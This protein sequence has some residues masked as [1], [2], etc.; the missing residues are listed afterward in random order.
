MTI[1]AAGVL[2]IVGGRALFLKRSMAGDHAGEWCLPAGKIEGD[3]TPEA[4]ARREFF[5]ETG[6]KLKGDLVLW[7]HR[8]GPVPVINAPTPEGALPPPMPPVVDFTCFLSVDESE[9]E[10]KVDDEHDGYAWAVPTSPPEPLHPGCRINLDRINMDELGMARAIMA[11]DL[12]SPQRFHNM[13]LFDL[14]ITG[15]ETAYRDTIDEIVYRLPDKY[16]SPDF[17]ARC[18][19]LAVIWEHPKTSAVL[20]S[21][22]YADRNIGTIMLPYIGDGVRH[23]A[24]EVWGIGKI[25]D[26]VAADLMINNQLSTSP[27]VKVRKVDQSKL[28]LEN[29]REVLIEGKP[30][31]LDHL[32]VCA[33]G[34]WDKGG[35][36]AGVEV[37]TNGNG[38]D[39]MN[40]KTDS[41]KT[42]AG[43][44]KTGDKKD[45]ATQTPIDMMLSKLDG[46]LAKFDA[47]GTKLDATCARLDSME[48]ESAK[49]DDDD[50]DKDDK[51]DGKKDAG[52]FEKK[53]AGAGFVRAE[54][55]AA[56]SKRMDE[57]AGRLPVH[58]TDADYT[59]LTEAQARADSV[60]QSFGGHAPRPMHGESPM[61]YRQRMFGQLKGH[62]SKWKDV[63]LAKVGDP[64]VFAVMEADVYADAAKAGNRP[65][66]L[67]PGQL[68]ERVRTDPSTGVRMI[69]FVSSGETFIRGM[70]PA[71][72][73][74]SR[75][76]VPTGT[77]A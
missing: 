67:K 11:G 36:P 58:L 73:A 49:K 20:N 6:H 29:G 47:F 13:W 12:V 68:I 18:N 54:D 35:E 61:A 3:E 43:D 27:A 74:V 77:R 51:K 14:R 8:I 41:A 46:A 37:T 65:T 33:V 55:F 38:D 10:P 64:S 40:T 19:G 48:K 23:P 66:D 2:C 4:A 76:G 45:G 63:D 56:V 26:D 9:F 39:A 32:A 60:M 53:D 22:E 42:D 57:L 62:S 5:E 1:K 70:L 72:R 59:A 69:T 44:D 21:K 15:T 16:L 52:M 17:V 71:R 34:V 25:Y 50:D 31:L 24:N 75:L 7:T 30:I 28:T